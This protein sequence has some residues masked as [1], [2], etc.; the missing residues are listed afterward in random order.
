MKK[1]RRIEISYAF[2]VFREQEDCRFEPKQYKKYLPKFENP[3]K[4]RDI[5]Q[6][7]TSENSPYL[8]VFIPGGHAALVNLPESEDVKKVLQ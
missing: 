4:L 8:G 1:R 7:V 3:L 6:Q 5:L 2:F